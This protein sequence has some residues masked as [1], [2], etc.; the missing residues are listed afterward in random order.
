MN[1]NFEIICG[2]SPQNKENLNFQVSDPNFVF[3]NDPLFE[4]VVLYDKDGNVVNVNSWIEC[5]HYVNGGWDTV[6]Y[7]NFGGDQVIFFGLVITFSFYIFLRRFLF[8]ND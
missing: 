2:V 8:S 7:Q 5:A 6:N 3:E 1:E 4:T